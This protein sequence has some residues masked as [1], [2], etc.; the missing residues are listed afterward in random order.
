MCTRANRFGCAA[1][2]V[3]WM[4]TA[5]P[6]SGRPVSFAC[7]S[8]SVTPHD[9][10]AARNASLFV[11]ASDCGRDDESK[12]TRAPRALLN[13]RPR[14]P[15][16]VDRTVSTLSSLTLPSLLSAPEDHPAIRLGVRDAGALAVTLRPFAQERLDP[17]RRAARW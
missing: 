12:A 17:N 4:V 3:P 15:L 5:M 11:S 7:I 10:T 8:I 14:V 16:L 13:A 2:R 1:V 9:E 6:A